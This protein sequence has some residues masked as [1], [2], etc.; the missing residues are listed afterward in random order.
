MQRPHFDPSTARS[1]AGAPGE[2]L[3]GGIDRLSAGAHEAVDQAARASAAAADLV[4][5]R[6]RELLAA[7]DEWMNATRAYVRAHPL[8]ALGIALAAGYVLSRVLSR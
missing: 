3:H 6:R 2:K 5:A 1:G 7:G 8:A 4:D